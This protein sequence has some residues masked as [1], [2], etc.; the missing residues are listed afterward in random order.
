M[1]R[2]KE[3]GSVRGGHGILWTVVTF[4]MF[5]PAQS[6]C[7]WAQPITKEDLTAGVEASESSIDDI[8]VEYE[9]AT[10][11][12]LG[13]DS[14][15]RFEP[16]AA[17]WQCIWKA[18]GRSGGQAYLNRTGPIV[19]EEGNI[20]ADNHETSAYDGTTG[21]YLIDSIDRGTKYNLVQGVILA[22][23]QLLLNTPIS[24]PERWSVRGMENIPLSEMLRECEEFQI[25]GSFEHIGGNECVVVEFLHGQHWKLFLDLRRGFSPLRIERYGAGRAGPGRLIG[26]TI[27]TELSEVE[28]GIW[29]PK[30]G[31]HLTSSGEDRPCN[32]YR[33]KTIKVNQ[34]LKDDEFVIHFAPGTHVTDERAHVKFTVGFDINELDDVVGDLASSTAIQ[35]PS[36]TE[37]Q[38]KSPRQGASTPAES[39]P[40]QSEGDAS[41]M[42]PHGETASP[43]ARWTVGLGVGIGCVIVGIVGFAMYRKLRGGN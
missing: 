25:S 22:E 20:L 31:M 18:K 33:A 38:S 16:Q 11:H 24:T 41:S 15:G 7:G 13:G 28:P 6:R 17:P 32:V 23:R 36:A 26:T 1:W 5:L 2:L 3:L 14:E 30:E 12:W 35:S 4:C 40:S 9:F 10:G 37:A 43:V 34:G 29:F 21:T 42:I 8:E 19:D 27:V 39:D